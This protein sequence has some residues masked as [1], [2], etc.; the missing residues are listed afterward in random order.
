MDKEQKLMEEYK[1][2]Q[3]YVLNLHAQ[4]WQIGA[5]LIAASLGTFALIVGLNTP[6]ISSIL[7][8]VISAFISSLLLGIWYL[9]TKRF[10]AFIQ[11]SYYRMRQIEA[12]L[13]LWRNRYIDYLDNPTKPEYQSMDEP[14]QK[15]LST[16]KQDFDAKYYRISA[17]HLVRLLALVIPVVWLLWIGYQLWS[18][19]AS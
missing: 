1:L 4:I 17:T 6:S 8:S 18:Y 16:L 10:A 3:D 19:W 7:I 12:E 2:S 5:I 13:G 11:V 9:I 15:S 14:A